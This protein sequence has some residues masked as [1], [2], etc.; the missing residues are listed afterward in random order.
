[1]KNK[2]IITDCCLLWEAND[3]RN[4]ILR[5]SEENHDTPLSDDDVYK[6]HNDDQCNEMLG[7]FFE[8]Y[9]HTIMNEIFELMDIWIKQ[10]KILQFTD[11]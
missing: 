11:K 9:S 7:K 5:Y 10:N 6:L 8:E 1:M 2:K 3:M 4:A